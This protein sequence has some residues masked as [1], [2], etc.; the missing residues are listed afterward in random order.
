MRPPDPGV[1]HAPL[2]PPRLPPLSSSGFVFSQSVRTAEQR[3][4][5]KTEQAWLGRSLAGL[6]LLSVNIAGKRPSFRV[7][8]CPVQVVPSPVVPHPT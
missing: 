6:Q 2:P 8:S 5:L 1:S 7:V 3:E 4:S